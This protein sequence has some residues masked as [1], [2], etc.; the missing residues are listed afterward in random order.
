MRGTTILTMVLVVAAIGSALA[1]ITGPA[2][3]IDGDTI[4]IAGQR[5]RLHA[6][7]APENGQTCLVGFEAWMCGQKATEALETFIGGSPVTC[8][9]QGVDRYGRTIAACSVRGRS[10]EAWMVLNGWAL[11]Y[12]QYS[13]DSVEQ[14]RRAQIAD[15]GMWRGEFVA[16]WEWRRGKRVLLPPLR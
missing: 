13:L 8:Q 3:V 9:E 1:D 6:I 5:I 14:E 12:R 11:A 7:D 10:I 4:D 2:R 16:L 15:L